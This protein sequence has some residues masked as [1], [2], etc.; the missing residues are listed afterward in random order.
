[1]YTADS[2]QPG[3]LVGLFVD[4]SPLQ[5]VHTTAHFAP[6]AV[7]NSVV[8]VQKGAAATLHCQVNS[9]GEKET[10]NEAYTYTGRDGKIYNELCL[11]C[12]IK[13]LD[14]K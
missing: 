9:L 7:N 14:R 1:M 2:P 6:G 12:E 10:V 8:Q 5:T 4:T 3:E 13:I 11:K